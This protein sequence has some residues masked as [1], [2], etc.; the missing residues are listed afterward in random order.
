MLLCMLSPIAKSPGPHLLKC[1]EHTEMNILILSADRLVFDLYLRR[2]AS[3]GSYLFSV[4]AVEL[5]D[6]NAEVILDVAGI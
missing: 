4:R 6:W 2:M 3:S 1:N 5:E